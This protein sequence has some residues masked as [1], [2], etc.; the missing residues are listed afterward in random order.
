VQKRREGALS[1][2]RPFDKSFYGRH[3]GTDRHGFGKI[4]LGSGVAN[5]LFIALAGIGGYSQHRNVAQSG[6]GLSLLDQVQPGNVGQLDVHDDEIGDKIARTSQSLATVGHRFDCVTLA[7]Q[8]VAE[9]FAVEIVVLD[10]EDSLCH[11]FQ[12]RFE[13]FIPGFY[14][15]VKGLTILR[16]RS[17]PFENDPATLALGAL[18]WVLPDDSRAQR[19]LA[20]TGMTPDSLRDGISDSAFLAAVLDFLC[21][22]EPDLI[23][24]A[25]HLGCAPATLA[26]AR[27]RLVR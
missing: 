9:Q 2:E 20:L 12:A 25:D 21:A 16:E 5:A 3:E 7:F 6:V 17:S 27:E 1:S 13:G 4:T 19:L 15:L 24:A 18:G 8:D 14:A 10:N 26:G 22:H 23:A 11:W